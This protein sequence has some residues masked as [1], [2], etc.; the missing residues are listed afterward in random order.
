MLAD[1][2]SSVVVCNAFTVVFVA[3]CPLDDLESRATHIGVI[4]ISI[5]VISEIVSIFL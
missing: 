2:V 5:A 3:C 4:V 1:I